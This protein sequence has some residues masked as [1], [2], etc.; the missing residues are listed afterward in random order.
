MP[1]PEEKT[2]LE[3]HSPFNFWREVALPV[4]LTVVGAVLTI[5]VTKWWTRRRELAEFEDELEEDL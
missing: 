3:V 4:T 5:E 1:E 2:P